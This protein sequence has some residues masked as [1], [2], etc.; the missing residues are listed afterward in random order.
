MES[1]KIAHRKALSSNAAIAAAIILSAVLVYSHGDEK[2]DGGHPPEDKS[3]V[4]AEARDSVYQIINENYQNVRH[5]FEK[6]C[7]DCHSSLTSFPWYYQIPGIKGMIDDDIS[8]AMEHFD[9][10]Q[11]FPFISEH[12]QID[13]LKDIKKEIASGDMP[14]LSYRMMHWG[15][16]I[17]GT[18]KDSV[19][20]WI[21][22]SIVL[23]ESME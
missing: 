6:S 13:L 21:D 4:N 7:F 23:L 10:S 1:L 16:L 19:F 5:I 12:S 11:D 14:L 9:L 18:S 3:P 22:S 8:E 17:E 20:D 15:T 2:R